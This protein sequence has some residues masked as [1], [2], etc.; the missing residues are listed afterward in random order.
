M[1]RFDMASQYGLKDPSWR[2]DVIPEI[3]DGK[4]ILDFV[5]ADILERLEALERCVP[6]LSVA[7][8]IWSFSW[9][10]RLHCGASEEEA[11]EET[12]QAA[13]AA[14]GETSEDEVVHEVAETI[15]AK[16]AMV[17]A[18]GRREKDRNHPR[19]NRAA[20]GMSGD[21]FAEHLEAVGIEADSIKSNLKKR[22]RSLTRKGA[23]DSG[24]DSA[25]DM[26]D[27]GSVRTGSVASKPSKKKGFRT[28]RSLSRARAVA[29]AG[30]SVEPEPRSRSRSRARN[31]SRGEPE[32]GE[33]F[34]DAK[35]K[36]S[37]SLYQQVMV[38]V[39]VVV[40]IL[41]RCAVCDPCDYGENRTRLGS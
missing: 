35:Q 20:M 31:A 37:S 25:S 10:F 39:V 28:Q 40:A 30:G 3:M 4:N 16:K 24:D 2:S 12:A 5:D 36:V 6:V 38:V 9:S 1:Y 11:D 19:L 41:T 21:K 23:A 13:A 15:R 18:R 33:G 34:K 14:E 22:G 27:V 29:A 8:S 32:Q 17:L 26:E 7:V